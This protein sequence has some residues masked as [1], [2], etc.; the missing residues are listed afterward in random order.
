MKVPAS[1]DDDDDDHH[2]L[3]MGA[4][5]RSL[6]ENAKNQYFGSHCNDKSS[7]IGVF[8]LGNIREKS[9]KMVQIADLKKKSKKSLHAQKILF[10]MK[11]KLGRF[12]W[13][14]KP[15]ESL[16]NDLD[17]SLEEMYFFFF[18]SGDLIPL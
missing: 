1:A 5:S 12:F 11:L 8:Q 7:N 4:R 6:R 10:F 3:E 16:K 9:N 2:H 17:F 13:Q 14:E 15:F 18:F